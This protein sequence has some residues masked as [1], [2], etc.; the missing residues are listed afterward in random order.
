M[1]VQLQ[2]VFSSKGLRRRK[3]KHQAAINQFA[4]IVKETCHM[5]SSRRIFLP[6]QTPHQLPRTRSRYAHDSNPPATRRCGNG[7]NRVLGAVHVP[8]KTPSLVRQSTFGGS[9]YLFP[10]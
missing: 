7:R 2:N 8:Q 9:R 3:K 1:G 4:S 5:N 10:P 6:G